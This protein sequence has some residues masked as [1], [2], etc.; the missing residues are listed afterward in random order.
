VTCLRCGGAM[1]SAR[2]THR[3]TETGLSNVVLVNVEMRACPACGERELVTPRIDVL[4]RAIARA[5]TRQT[6]ALTPEAVRFLRRWL[7]LT[8]H[9]FARLMGVRHQTVC[10]WERLDTACP[11]TPPADRLLKMLVA[12]YDATARYP[13]DLF[14]GERQARPA[15]IRLVSPDWRAEDPDR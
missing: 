7:G 12:Q 1:T 4:H 9:R 6:G 8:I 13:L 10:R 3:Y 2:G 11:L 15:P 14:T 5:L